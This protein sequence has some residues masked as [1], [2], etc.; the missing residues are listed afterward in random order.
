VRVA[1]LGVGDRGGRVGVGVVDA[2]GYSAEDFTALKR[3][4]SSG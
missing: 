1:G 2:A 4:A 3:A